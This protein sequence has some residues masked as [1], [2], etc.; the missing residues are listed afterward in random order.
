MTFQVPVQ[1]LLSAHM[2]SWV[3]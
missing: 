2:L 1:T 3:Q